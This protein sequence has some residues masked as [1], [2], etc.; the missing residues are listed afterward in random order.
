[1]KFEFLKQ[2]TQNLMILNKNLLRTLESEESVLDF[3]IKY[4]IKTGKL[5]QL[6]KGKY[7]V[8]EVFDRERN[9]DIY[10]EYITSKLVEPSY[11][12]VEYVLSKYQILSEP[13]QSITS[14]TTKKT[15]EIN[16]KLGVFRYYSIS[17][18]LFKGYNIKNIDNFVVAEAKKSK[19]LFD[20]LYF[21]FLKNSEVSLVAVQN[22]RLNWENITKEEFEDAKKYS[23]FTSSK[24]VKKIF[25]IIKDEYYV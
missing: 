17:N 12:S 18:K 15:R 10:L 8:A 22:L 4:W 21:R 6:E 13:V 2:S 23:E 14:V 5:V 20:F 1:M 7:I 11:L 24:R 3:N 19:A 25:Q 16:N 9:K